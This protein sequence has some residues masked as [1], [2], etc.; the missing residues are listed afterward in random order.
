[1]AISDAFGTYTASGSKFVNTALV[2][3]SLIGI[4]AILDS[5]FDCPTSPD[6]GYS[7]ALI[8]IYSLSFFFGPAIVFIFIGLYYFPGFNKKQC[9]PCWSGNWA[10]IY[11]VL[12][13]G[14]PALI[15][16]LIAMTDGR[17]LSCFVV[18]VSHYEADH[19]FYLFVFQT[20]G[21]LT[22]TLLV[23]LWYCASKCTCM[24]LEESRRAY[25][26]LADVESILVEDEAEKEK[27]E[28]KEKFLNALEHNGE[29]L[30]RRI[31]KYMVDKEEVIVAKL[32]AEGP[33]AGNWNSETSGNESGIL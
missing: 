21:M 28:E 10:C 2:T 16:L 13:V 23:I 18:A 12:K 20:T 22:I 9:C 29:Y 26:M 1:M 4:Q 15:W 31:P 8:G 11:V 25:Q 24:C 7:V 33:E 19:A 27:K 32:K 30:D 17:Y 6:S 14:K 3:F 5:N